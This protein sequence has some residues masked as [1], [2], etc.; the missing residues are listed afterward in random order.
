MAHTYHEVLGIP[1][2][3]KNQA[4]LN[5]SNGSSV[6]G[7]GSASCL[8]RK[9]LSC[10]L[11]LLFSDIIHVSTAIIAVIATVL[12]AVMSVIMSI[13]YCCYCH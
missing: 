13:N 7:G 8:T 12:S 1:N 9:P 10:V 4:A 3:R 6:P 11:L 5:L 2:E